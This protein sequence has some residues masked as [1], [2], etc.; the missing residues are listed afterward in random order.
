MLFQYRIVCVLLLEIS[1]CLYHQVINY[2][3]YLP[4]ILN[5]DIMEEY[6]LTLR[7]EGYSYNYDRNVNPTIANS[8]GAAAFRYIYD[9]QYELSFNFNFYGTTLWCY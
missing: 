5:D 3:E 6:N 9:I 2:K 7:S 1:I 4:T 8:F